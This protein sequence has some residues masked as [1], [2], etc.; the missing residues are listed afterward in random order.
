MAYVAPLVSFG[1]VTLLSSFE[2]SI[3][4]VRKVSLSKASLKGSRMWHCVRL[5]MCKSSVTTT[6]FVTKQG[7]EVSLDSN[8]KGS[9]NVSNANA[10]FVLKPSP[11]PPQQNIFTP[12]H[13]IKTESVLDTTKQFTTDER[14][15]HYIKKPNVNSDD[16]Q[17]MNSDADGLNI[18]PG[19]EW[20]VEVVCGIHNH[21]SAKYLEGHSYAERLSKEE[22]NLLMDMS[23]SLVRPKDIL[24]TIKRRDD[25]NVTIM[26]TIYKA[27]H[28]S[29]VV[30]KEDNYMWAL[31]RLKSIMNT[32]CLPGVIVTD[33]EMELMNANRNVFPS[34]RHFLCRWHINRC[35]M[36]ACKGILKKAKTEV[37]YERNPLKMDRIFE[38]KYSKA[39]DY[40]KV[41]WLKEY[42]DRFVV[43]WI[44]T[45]MHFSNTTSNR[46]EN[47]HSQLKQQLGTSQC[48]FKTSWAKIHAML[49]LQ[50]TKI[51][52]SFKKSQSFV[53]HEFNKVS[54][55][56]DLI[57][58]VSI[59]A[60]EETLCESKRIQYVGADPIAC[61]YVIRRSH[62]LPCTHEMAEL[63]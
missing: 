2:R 1:S 38:G 3:S 11:K 61:S 58:Y 40:V 45:C 14:G 16:E 60:L 13:G 19:D 47:A 5:S 44:D 43:V 32:N 15:G 10:D 29:R 52:A 27:R 48:N 17:P 46:A 12:S 63:S 35:V 57:G 26:K 41:N 22:N 20:K 50:H 21:H 42:K 62:G 59:V 7:N 25:K 53:Q 18:G 4:L 8:Y 51:K 54:L 34:V 6:N 37:D 31:N 49:I 28:K 33:K 24:Y 36:K 30:E 55:L 56:K 39:L 23:K 9:T